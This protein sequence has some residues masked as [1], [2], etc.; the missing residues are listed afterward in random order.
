MAKAKTQIVL[1]NIQHIPFNKLILSQSNVRRVKNGL[2]IEVLAEDIAHRGLLQNLIVRPFINEKHEE[3]GMFDVP[4][5]GRRFQALAILVKQKRLAKDAAIPCN[6]KSAD[7]PISPEEDSLAE[8]TFRAGLHPLDEYRAFHSLSLLGLGHE[9][10][11]A[12]FNTTPQ[13]VKQRLKLASVSP[14]LLEVY[15]ANGMTLEQLMAFTLSDDHTRQEQIWQGVNDGIYSDEPSDI[16]ALLTEDTIS[17]DDRR[18]L[19]VGL[20]NYIVAGGLIRRDLFDETDGGYLEDA[21][22]VDR[23]FT[24]QLKVDGEKVGAEGWKWVQVSS[25]FPVGHSN[26][27]R[28]IHGKVV[29]LTEEERN[30]RQT[31][32]DEQE[33]IETK[34]GET[35]E[36]P[37]EVNRRYDELTEAIDAFE[38]RP[39]AYDP[40]EMVYAGAFVRI[41]QAGRLVIER[42][43]VHPEDEPRK[44][45]TS[46]PMAEQGEADEEGAPAPVQR[47]VI[48]I[49]DQ[50]SEDDAGDNA[51][52]PLADRLV[53]E[54]TSHRTI[55]LQESVAQNPDA[56]LTVLLHKF[57]TDLFYK[58]TVGGCLDAAVRPVS[59]PVQAPGLAD[60]SSARA[61][62]ER[63]QHFQTKLP[64]SHDELWDFLAALS[65]QPR[66]ELLAFCVSQG[67]SAY[68]DRSSS[69]Y[70]MERRIASANHLARAVG[71]DMV[72][73]GWQPTVENY[74]GRVTKAHILEAVREAKGDSSAQLIDHLKKDEMAKEAERLL[75]NSGWLPEPLRLTDVQAMESDEALPAFLAGDP[76]AD[77]A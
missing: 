6:V 27:L 45:Q 49:G 50:A 70:Q 21:A 77:A 40:A 39:L 61:Q 44:S 26:G 32:R 41:D 30:Q 37:E 17:T 18:V 57:V 19:Y 8:N 22:L 71:L 48:T 23:L 24:E 76:V 2:S 11:A 53:S 36:C 55:A 3:I 15:G 67:I 59:M 43:Y 73:V 54:L 38:E 34:Y 74:L 64:Q 16:K 66:L 1:G 33:A 28:R 7:D 56:A 9:T 10:I 4:A 52:K 62:E 5:G 14:K 63:E 20:D 65:A 35:D 47:A 68:H 58:G 69:T 29:P 72:A 42:G 25:S 46:S 31:L 12:R 60:T 13:I 51:V 75:E